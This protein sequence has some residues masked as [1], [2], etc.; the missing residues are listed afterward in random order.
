VSAENYEKLEGLDSLPFRAWHLPLVFATCCVAEYG[1][2][3]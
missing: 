1:F 2:G 3:W